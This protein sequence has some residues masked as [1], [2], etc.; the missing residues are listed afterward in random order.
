VEVSEKNAEEYA[1]ALL[2]EEQEKN[3]KAERRRAKNKKVAV[4]TVRKLCIAFVSLAEKRSK[5]TKGLPSNTL[6]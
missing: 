4:Y 6:C 1:A 2:Q 5:E 3:Q